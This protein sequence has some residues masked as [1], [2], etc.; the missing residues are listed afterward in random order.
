MKKNSLIIAVLSL[1][2]STNLWAWGFHTHRKLTAEAFR[3]M[4]EAFQKRFANQKKSFL[5]G[6]TDPDTMIQD[7]TNHIFY[8]DGTQT[9]GLYRIQ[10][11]FNRSV[12]L[13]SGEESDEKRAYLL[14]L[15]S[16]YIADLNQPLH[17]AGKERDPF[18]DKYHSRHET[19]VNRNLRNFSF[20]PVIER[21]LTSVEE[22]VREMAGAAYRHYDAIGASYRAETDL[23]PIK[24]MIEKQLNASVQHIVDFWNAAVRSSRINLE[25]NL[26]STE[27][28][29]WN[30]E[31]ETAAKNEQIN[32]N[33]ASAGEISA[34]FRI[35]DAKAQKVVDSRPFRNAY[36]LAR[37][38]VF[39]AMY[40]KRHK[41]KIKLK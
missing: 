13:L 27:K 12:E 40:I 1:F 18:E 14:G 32:I 19:D 41:D 3:N 29:S 5:K 15:L 35:S 22:R 4:P 28:V 31:P 38:G 21:P 30:L 33:S 20:K 26:Q 6:C 39:T 2:I 24:Q 16:H 9:G 34:F 7:F 11:L 10:D 17:T 37:T 25:N 36:D 8:P 23:N